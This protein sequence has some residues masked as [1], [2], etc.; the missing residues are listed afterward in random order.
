MKALEQHSIRRNDFHGEWNYT[1]LP[2]PQPT[3]PTS[4]K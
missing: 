1:L 4:P 2:A 3:H